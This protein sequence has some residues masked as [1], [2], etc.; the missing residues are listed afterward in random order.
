MK[1][2]IVQERRVEDACDR[3][4]LGRGDLKL[5][6]ELIKSLI[7]KQ[8]ERPRGL[9]A[10]K[11]INVFENR[12]RI[13]LWVEYEEESVTK[14]KIAASYFAVLDGEELRIRS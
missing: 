7:F 10:V 8:V 5:N 11:A 2:N 1:P 12:Y 13:N 9:I 4:P 14:R 6:D 3:G